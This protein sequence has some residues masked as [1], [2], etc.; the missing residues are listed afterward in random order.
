MIGPAKSFSLSIS[1]SLF[2][3]GAIRTTSMVCVYQ[4]LSC[5]IEVLHV[6]LSPTSSIDPSQNWRRCCGICWILDR[7]VSV[8]I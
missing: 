2:F 7:L 5:E 3:L 6:C 4:L 1:L 8:C